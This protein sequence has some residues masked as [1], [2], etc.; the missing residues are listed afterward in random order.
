[1]Q[2]ANQILFRPHT[3]AYSHTKYSSKLRI[4]YHGVGM[5]LLCSNIVSI[6]EFFHAI[7]TIAIQALLVCSNN[8]HATIEK[9]QKGK[10]IPPTSTHHSLFFILAAVTDSQNVTA[11]LLFAV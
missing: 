9:T 6:L 1:M 11:L 8:A 10:K 3:H 2:L 5:S 7:A 4:G